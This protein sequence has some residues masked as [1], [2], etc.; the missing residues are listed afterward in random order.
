MRIFL[1]SLSGHKD[2]E[3][4]TKN[5]KRCSDHNPVIFVSFVVLSVLGDHFVPDIKNTERT[6]RHVRFHAGYPIKK[7]LFFGFVVLR[8]D[9]RDHTLALKL[10][11]AGRN[12]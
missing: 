7:L 8:R 1:I 3:E 9:L 2:H 4:Y 11:D 12:N 10:E 6:R 5:T